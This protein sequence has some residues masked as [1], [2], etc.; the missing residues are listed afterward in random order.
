MQA[1]RERERQDRQHPKSQTYSA[2]GHC[3]AWHQ[4]P[5]SSR[6]LGV[7]LCCC[8]CSPHAFRMLGWILTSIIAV[9]KGVC[10]CMH[11]VRT[12][13]SRSR[14][15]RAPPHS[16][17]LHVE[18]HCGRAS[19][20]CFAEPKGH[21]WA[22]GQKATQV[23]SSD[24]FRPPDVDFHL[25]NVLEQVLT[26]YEE[27]CFN[28]RLYSELQVLGCK[29]KMTTCRGAPASASGTGRTEGTGETCRH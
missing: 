22:M 9:E 18:F 24:D 10:E 23:R 28:Y 7:V 3:H 5:V 1:N 25:G 27:S 13:G 2:T 17:I 14:S 26:T 12:Q 4:T 21:V 29:S 8:C 11:R 16:K 19:V 20:P 6:S 15:P